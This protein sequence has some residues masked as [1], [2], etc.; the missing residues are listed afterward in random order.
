MSSCDPLLRAVEDIGAGCVM[1]V[2]VP[3]AGKTSI[4]RSMLNTWTRG[5]VFGVDLLCVMRY[6]H[7]TYLMPGGPGSA[8]V[9]MPAGSLLFVDEIDA[10]MGRGGARWK[11]CL[12]AANMVGALGVTMIVTARDPAAVHFEVRGCCRLWICGYL[13]NLAHAAEVT[14]RIPDAAAKIEGLDPGEQGKRCGQF[15]P[16]RLW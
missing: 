11:W 1:L 6:P 14:K 7:V 8:L 4:L 3:R 15:L 16:F 10:V 13:A 2:A 12:A 5:P 9:Q